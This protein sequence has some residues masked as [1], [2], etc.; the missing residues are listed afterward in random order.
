MS[1]AFEH[2][3]QHERERLAAIEGE[4]DSCSIACLTAIGVGPGWRCFEVGAGAGSIG[5][6]GC[7]GSMPRSLVA[8]FE[9]RAYYHRNRLASVVDVVCPVNLPS[10][11]SDAPRTTCTRCAYDAVGQPRGS[12]GRVGWTGSA[13][14]SFSPPG[15]VSP[16]V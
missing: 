1:Y 11:P 13:G 9:S 2:S 10:I 12:Q 5:R 3:W 16:T 8:W 15:H 14:R 4:L 6:A 7:L